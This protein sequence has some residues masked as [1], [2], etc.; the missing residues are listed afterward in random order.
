MDDKGQIIIKRI[1]WAV[2]IIIV[3]VFIGLKVKNIFFGKSTQ[4]DESPNSMSPVNLADDVGDNSFSDLISNVSGLVVDTE[5]E[6]I[7]RVI[8]GENVKEDIE[9]FQDGSIIGIMHDDGKNGDSLANDGVYSYQTMLTPDKP[10][11]DVVFYAKAGSITGNE[12]K[13][14]VYS[15]P[16][17]KEIQKESSLFERLKEIEKKY[18]VDGYVPKDKY[19]VAVDELYD[20][21]QSLSYDNNVRIREI[22]KNYDGISI[23]FDS[24]FTYVYT[25]KQEGSESGDGEVKL[26]V[27]TL[28]PY[29]NADEDRLR[30]FTSQAEQIA[31]TLWDQTSVKIFG[32]MYVNFEN[33]KNSFQP[34][35]FIIWHGHGGYTESGDSFLCTGVEASI[36]NQLLYTVDFLT[37]KMLITSDNE[38][39]ITYRYF[40]S[41]IKDLSN[42]FVYLGGCYTGKDSY[43]MSV[44]LWKN[45]E[46]SVGFTDSVRSSY[47]CNIISEMVDRL[48]EKHD[49]RYRT[50][51]YSLGCAV[52]KYGDN[53]GDDTPAYVKYYG[54][55]EYRIDDIF[56]KELDLPTDVVDD[57][58]SQVDDTI[59]DTVDKTANDISNTIQDSISSIILGSCEGC[60]NCGN[61]CGNS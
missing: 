26:T 12:L 48:C 21:A 37:G 29:A 5:N 46:V 23:L 44:M 24:G 16:D 41:N 30:T 56:P 14:S 43:L 7:L 60:V 52:E 51:S 27:V 49:G 45:A 61:D 47:D 4:S 2:I 19:P 6:V 36:S 28:E 42:S 10:N 58:Q 38:I 8:K 13:L 55:E 32:D 54:N 35:S 40:D 31:D 18:A 3:V 34:N 53:D 50:I 20:Y 25:F 11:V 17:E 1:T 33:I 57:I 22:T 39:G 9:L 59:N 15:I